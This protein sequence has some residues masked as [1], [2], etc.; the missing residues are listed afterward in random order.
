MCRKVLAFAVHKWWNFLQESFC[1][2]MEFVQ[3]IYRFCSPQM[4]EFFAGKFLLKDG[5]FGRKV[6]AFAVYKW[7]NFLQESCCWMMKFMQKMYRLC[8]PHVDGICTEKFSYEVTSLN[9]FWVG[10]LLLGGI[11]L[12][13]NFT[14]GEF[15]AWGNFPRGD[16]SCNHAW[17]SSRDGH[18]L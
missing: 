16:F 8:S 6:L 15:S 4:L 7:W 2:K 1:L 11:C 10:E 13:E 9:I 3:E 18:H 5:T 17:P 14:W 12:G